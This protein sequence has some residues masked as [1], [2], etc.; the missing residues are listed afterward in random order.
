MKLNREHFPQQK[1]HVEFYDWKYNRYK[2]TLKCLK[3]YMAFKNIRVEPCWNK[4]V[5]K[6]E[7][8]FKQKADGQ[9][10]H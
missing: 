8:L 5:E 1:A 10:L 7:N 4:P 6:Q 9:S 3:Y 2:K